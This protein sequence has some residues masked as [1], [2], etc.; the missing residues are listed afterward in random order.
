MD[1]K[2]DFK[3]IDQLNQTPSKISI[4]SLLLS[5]EAHRKAL[6]EVLNTAH[7][8]QD[9]TVSQFVDGVANITTSRYLGFNEAGLPPKGNA[10]NKALHISVTCT[11]S[12]LSRV[13]IDTGSS[14][15]V[16]PKSTLSQIQFKGPEMRTNALI[17]RAFDGFGRQV[18][19][20]VD[21]P[22]CVGSH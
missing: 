11:D 7:V 2:S 5:C 9:T 16:L 22:I 10:Q 1:Q 20:E 4:L 13:L 15:N 6:L 17:V 21:L 8:M 14:L 3:I 18:I 19:G 12:L